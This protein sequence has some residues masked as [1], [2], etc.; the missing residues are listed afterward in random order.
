MVKTFHF[1]LKMMTSPEI[2]KNLESLEAIFI[3]DFD[4]MEF[5]EDWEKIF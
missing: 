4:S 5:S 2:L 3:E 1:P